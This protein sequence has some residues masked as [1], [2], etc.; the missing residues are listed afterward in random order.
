[1]FDALDELLLKL[2]IAFIVRDSKDEI[3]SLSIQRKYLEKLREIA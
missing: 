3:P 1:M 2:N